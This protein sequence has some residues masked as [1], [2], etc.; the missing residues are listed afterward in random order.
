MHKDCPA[1]W[2]FNAVDEDA[3]WH[4]QS[5][6]KR[7]A[8]AF[9]PDSTIE[10]RLGSAQRDLKV[11]PGGNVWVRV[12]S[13][14]CR[15]FLKLSGPERVARGFIPTL[16][17]FGGVASDPQPP[18]A[19]LHRAVAVLLEPQNQRWTGKRRGRKEIPD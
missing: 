13:A 1:E 16:S 6:A 5:A 4:T 11:P 9:R 15:Q 18:V 10:K 2:M 3:A 12:R 8:A 17:R 19:L 14:S 7:R